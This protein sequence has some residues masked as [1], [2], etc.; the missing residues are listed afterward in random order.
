M[1]TRKDDTIDTP[2]VKFSGV[3]NV[4]KYK[5]FYLGVWDI[6]QPTINYNKKGEI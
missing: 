2:A 5:Q 4:D 3:S 1:T 6:T